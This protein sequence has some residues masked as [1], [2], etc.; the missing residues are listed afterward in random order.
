MSATIEKFGVECDGFDLALYNSACR[1]F[2]VPE[3]SI[4]SRVSLLLSIAVAFSAFPPVAQA[5]RLTDARFREL[6]EE[7]KPTGNEP[8]R[9]IP[10]RIALLDAQQ[11]AAKEGK[12]IFI[13]AMDG[14]P[15]GCT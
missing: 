6:L 10:W 9:T 8:W 11:A 4:M 1:I 15:L 12:P 5:E 13:W 7:L 3:R 14:H 2:L